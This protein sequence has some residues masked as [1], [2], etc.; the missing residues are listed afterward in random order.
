MN[1]HETAGLRWLLPPKEADWQPL[2]VI[3]FLNFNQ[4]VGVDNWTCAAF[5]PELQ[6]RG[7]HFPKGEDLA[8]AGWQFGPPVASPLESL[9]LAQAQAG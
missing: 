8:A 6:T 9:R 2:P 5:P 4:C 3:G 1:G 7:I